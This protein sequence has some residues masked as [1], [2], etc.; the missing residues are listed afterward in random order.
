[1]EK[2]HGK[3][4]IIFLELFWWWLLRPNTSILSK[5]EGRLRRHIHS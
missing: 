4:T 1:M 2:A 5:N 3:G